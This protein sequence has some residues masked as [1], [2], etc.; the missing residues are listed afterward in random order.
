MSA[1]AHASAR[2]WLAVAAAILGAFMAILDILVTNAALANIQGALGASAE[3][4][5]W[6][7]TAYLMAEIIVIPLT[8]WLSAVIGLRR[9]LTASTVLFIGFSVACALST[10]LTQMIVARAGQGLTGGVLIPTALVIVRTRLPEPQQP[11][12]IALFGL[13]A[14]FAPAIG[15]TIGGWLTD[16]LAWHYIFYLNLLIGPLTVALQLAALEPE[17]PRWGELARGDWPGVGLM[18]LGL[19]ALTFVLEEGQRKGWFGSDT[20][21]NAAILAGLGIAGFIARELT[22]ERPFINLRVLADRSVGGSCALMSVLGAVSYGSIY[23]I[24]VYC[25]QI[26][27]YNAEQIGRVVMWSGLPQLLVFPLMPLLTR[28]VDAR[29]LIAVGTGFFIASCWINAGLSHDVGRDQLILPQVLRAIGQPLFVVPLS[30]LATAGLSVRDTADASALMNMTR[31]LGGSVGIAVLSTMIQRR[32]HMHF[33]VIAEAITGN[34]LR[35]Q[36]HLATLAAGFASR[37]ADPE[38]AHERAV[39]ALA[40]QVRREAYVMAY[41][42]GFW[43]VGAG[44]TV[45]LALVLLLRPSSGSAASEAH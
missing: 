45:S 44:L 39:A 12:G 8:G 29:I 34:A 38:M 19:P 35:T 6:I 5:S 18:M 25:A 23:L 14:T 33:S 16:N 1:G 24:P 15:P 30:Q 43:L 28:R 2:D 9:Y 27:G 13:T 11:V 37:I 42:D 3:E 40:A 32:D 22:A 7:S 36:Q 21:R 10:N 17:A 31:N 20:I 41:A 26:Q 4:G